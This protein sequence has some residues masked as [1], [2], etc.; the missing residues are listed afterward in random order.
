MTDSKL[1]DPSALPAVDPKKK[2]K[3]YRQQRTIRRNKLKAQI[4][5]VENLQSSAPEFPEDCP[6]D[7]LRVFVQQALEKIRELDERIVDLI[8]DESSQDKEVAEAEEFNLEIEQISAIIVAIEGRNL[9]GRAELEG[10]TFYGTPEAVRHVRFKP[11]LHSTLHSG[12]RASIA[13][14]TPTAPLFPN[15]SGETEQPPIPA[16]VVTSRLPRELDISP[17]AFSGDRLKYRAFIIQFQCFVNKRPESSALERLMTLRKF[18]TGEPRDIVHSLELVDSNYEVALQLLNENYGRADNETE[19]ILS[20]L[21]NLPRIAKYQDVSALRKLTTSVQANIAS[22]AANGVPLAAFAPSLRS[23]LE[24]AV[25]LRMRQEFRDARRTEE[26]ILA[27]ARSAIGETRSTPIPGEGGVVNTADGSSSCIPYVEKSVTEVKKMI[28]FLRIRIRDWED[29]RHFDE[30]AR[31]T[32]NGDTAEP[33]SGVKSKQQRHRST[34]AGATSRPKPANVP[35]FRPRPCLFCKTSEHNSS[36]CT[37]DITLEKRKELLA[38]QRR[39]DKCFR[40]THLNPSEC[41]GPRSPCSICK[42]AHHY[43]S[44]HPSGT[45]SAAIVAGSRGMS[46]EPST[47]LWTTCAHVV[48]SGMKIPVR[49]FLDNGSTLTVIS[50]AL[51]AMLREAPV[52]VNNLSIQAFASVHNR[53]AVPVYSVRLQGPK[54]G[55]TLEFFA[56]EYDFGVDPANTC[57]P[58]I[59][60]A[61]RKFD[62]KRPLADRSYLGEW[63]QAAPM[64]LIGMDQLHKI[65][66][67]ATP[68]SVVE[69]IEAQQ[70]HFGWVVGGSTG[71]EEHRVEGVVTAAHIVCCSAAIA[72]CSSSPAKA[73]ETL[74]N[75]DSIGINDPPSSS[76]LSADEESALRQFNESVSYS[77]G[78]YT[79][80]FPKRATIAQLPNNK[81]IARQRLPKK[82]FQ[83]QQ[84]PDQYQQYHEEVMKFGNEG[85]AVPVSG[86]DADG[87]ATVDGFMPHHHVTSGPRD[88]ER[89][90]IVFDCSSKERGSTSLNNHLLVGPN[91]NPDLLTVFLSFRLH[92]IAVSADMAKAYMRISVCASDQPL[93]RFLWKPPWKYQDGPLSCCIHGR[94][95]PIKVRLRP[96]HQA[97][98]KS[99]RSHI[100][101]CLVVR[102][103]VYRRQ[104]V[105]II[106]V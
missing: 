79:V 73:I 58:P 13:P 67:R 1:A 71:P 44:M 80:A 54:G 50:P 55:K 19:R 15:V 34:I 83:L 95:D 99:I 24:A 100:V 82:I 68:E 69:N 77:D 37:A 104:I 41:R 30:G 96:T 85:F 32:D 106:D 89:W 39:C 5:R 90:R 48:N 88:S 9:V 11:I 105:S 35:N 59:V 87:P 81:Q 29:N 26:K 92:P 27:A 21:R 103:I 53:Q 12:G 57:P 49:V 52:A 94:L 102:A 25:P 7:V 84:S 47:L 45:T 14:G 6:P 76:S 20:E 4:A 22:L 60:E 8:E 61:I 38:S 93:F 31:S 64:M 74:W 66:I 40:N 56:H 2:L 62:E 78:R 46:T 101:S 51:R 23:A 16:A 33:R 86:A 18:L 42:S 65:V 97:R 75:L 3:K 43:T 70:T 36:R 10:N 98:C 63:S 91:L 28:E 72:A 17:E